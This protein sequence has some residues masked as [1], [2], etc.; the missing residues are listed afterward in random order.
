MD[1]CQGSSST[2]PSGSASASDSKS[3][4]G[5]SV[6]V[7]AQAIPAGQA[8]K[9][10][11]LQLTQLPSSPMVLMAR[12][13]LPLAPFLRWTFPRALLYSKGRW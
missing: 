3:N 9:A 6:V 12:F 7:A 8:L 11:D 10:E 5:M 2:G 13:R 4:A 1:A